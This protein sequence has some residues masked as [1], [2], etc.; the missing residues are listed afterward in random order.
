MSE[1]RETLIDFPC[2]FPIKAMGKDSEKFTQVV[3]DLVRPH[4][5]EVDDSSIT[6]RPS[7]G[8][9]FVSVTITVKATSRSQLDSIYQALTDCDQILMSL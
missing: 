5:P 2:D 8:G 4:A 3:L 9:K 1:E 7:K 6:T